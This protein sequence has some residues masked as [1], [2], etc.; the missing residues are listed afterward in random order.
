MQTK[1]E[2]VKQIFFIKERKQRV[3]NFQVKTS[4]HIYINPKGDALS[5]LL[6]F[7][8][9]YPERIVFINDK[10]THLKGVEDAVTSKGFEFILEFGQ[11]AVRGEVPSIWPFAPARGPS[12]LTTFRP[13]EICIFLSSICPTI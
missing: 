2:A 8:G 10:A 7:I 9:I 11:N 6:D 4:G 13:I 12:P 3:Y 5:K 1:L